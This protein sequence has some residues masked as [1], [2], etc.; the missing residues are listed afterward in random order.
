M[1]TDPVYRAFDICNAK[2]AG[3]S[4]H[5]K[6]NCCRYQ[7]YSDFGP[8]DSYFVVKRHTE[9]NYLLEQK[10]Y[11]LLKDSGVVSTHDFFKF[12]IEDTMVPHIVRQRLTKY[13]MADLVYAF[14]HFDNNKC[15]VLK[16]ILI[17]RGC[18]QS[19]YFDNPNWYDPVENPDV[20]NVYHKLGETV[21]LA[22]LSAVKMADY[23]VR[24][25][26]VGVLT[27]DNQDLNGMWYDFGDFIQ[28]VP[29]MGVPVMDTYYSLAMPV[30]SM[31]H[32]LAAEGH[33]DSDIS[34]PLRVWDVFTYDYT[35][36]RNELFHKYFKYWDTPY[37]PNCVN[38]G[39]DRCVLHCAN[40]NTLF[41]MVIPPTS[42]GPLVQKIYVDGVPFVVS[43]G[44]HYKELGVVFN[45]D[46]KLHS[47]RLS[48]SELLVYAAD[49]AM[50]VAASTALADHRTVCLSVAALTTGVTFQTVKPGHFNQDFY[51]FAIKCGFF[52]EGSSIELKHF[53][54]AQDGNAA[55]KDYNYYRYN[56]PTMCDIK[57]LLFTMEVVDKYFECY[58]GGCL[59]A[60][61]VI[62]ANY[63]K[64][65][66]FPFNKFGK[67]R[68]YY[69]SLSYEDQDGLFAY[70]KRNVLPTITQMNLKY[71]ISAKERAR[72]VAGVSIVSTMTNRQYHQK[73]LK[74]IAA[75]RGATVVI[76]TTKFY[77]GW[78]RMLRTLV[79]DVDNPHLMG[80]D[81]PKCDRAMPNML[82]IFASLI[83]ARKHQTCCN[84]SERFYRLANECAQVL[85]EMVLCGGGFYVKP[86]G[87]SSGDSTT[88][89]ANSVFNICQAVTANLGTLLS[90]DGNK[91]YNVAVKELQRR[92]YMG[93]YRSSTL[94]TALV[95]DYYAFLRK[96]FSMMILSDDGVV[97]YNSEYAA[98][99]Y[100]ADIQGFKETLYYQ[101]NVFMSESKCWVESDIEKGPHEFCSQHTM[102]CD[103][104]GE[105]V[106][107]PYPDPS[108]IL[109]AGCFVDDLIK[110][111][112]TLLLERY[113]SLAIDAY[114][115][116]KHSDPEYQKV[117]WLY[118]QYIK[119]L[120]EELT[121]HM[122]DTYSV[123]ISSENACKYW[124]PEFYENM[125]SEST[126]L[127][128]VGVCVVCNS[129]T[130]LRCGSCLR[131][132]FL[133][134]KCCYDHVM[135]TNH[136]LV[137]S[138]TPYVCNSP[139]CDQAD[140]TQLY[141]GG[142]SY[143]CKLHKPPIA[144][145]LCSNGQVF[146]LYKNMCTGSTDVAD[147]N[148]LST[149]DW[150]S[151]EDYV[152]ANTVS[153]RLRLFAAETLRATEEY[154]KQAYASAVIK[155]VVSERELVLQWEPGKVRPPLNRNYVFTGYHIAKNSKI[156]LGEYVFEKA[157]F[158]DG[159]TYRSTTTYK[160]QVGDKFV[161]TSHS[162][163]TLVSPTLV[164]QERYSKLVGLYP[165]LHMPESYAGNICHYQRIG[166]SKYTT[167]QGPPGTG[168][169]HLAIGLAIYYP[170]AKIVYTACSHAAV[171][172]LCEKA[173]LS[174]PIN[175]CSRIVPA[176]AR[177]ECFSRFKV[178]D[179]GAQYVFSTINALPETSVD[180]LVV[181]E[182]SMCTNYDLSMINARV[183]A[184]HIVYIGD[185]SQLPAPRTLLTRG[186]L[187]PEH[188][189]AICR[190]MVSVG[191]DIFLGIC[192]RCPKE[193][194]ST[195]S[196]LVY[197]N[198]LRANKDDT[199]QCFKCYFK[200]NV[201][202][203]ASSA[204]NKPQLML[205]REFITQHPLWSK[206]VF[207]SPYNSQNAV[208]RKMLGLQTQT[209]DSSQGSEFDYVIFTQTSDTSHALNLNRFN[210]AITRARKG[211]LCVMSDMTLFESLQFEALD[212]QRYGK[213]AS[214]QSVTVGLFKDCSKGDALSP[215][216]A[217]TYVSVNDKY[218][219][220]D[221]LCV[222]LEVDSG[223]IPYARLISKMGFKFDVNLPDYGK[224]FITKE[225]AI[226]EVRGWIGFDV[227]G[228]HACGPNLGT[229]L[230]LQVGFSTG[231][232][233]LVTPTGFVD[234][235]D[236]TQVTTVSARAPP[237]EQFKHLVPLLRKGEPWCVVRKRIVNMLCDTLDGVSDSV[238][239][240][241]WAH[242]FELTTMHYFCKVGK[243][244]KCYMCSR[245]AVLYASCYD[246]YSCWSHHSHVGGADYI[247]NPFLV[248]VQQWGYSGNLQAN[249]DVHCSVH[250]GAH[251]ASCDAIMTRCLAVYTCFAKV[252]WNLTY[253]II[254]NELSINKSCRRLQRTMLNAVVRACGVNKIY[255]IGNPK[256][257]PVTGVDVDWHFYDMN[258]VSDRVQSLVYSYEVHKDMFKDGLT[259]FWNC[260]VD[261]YPANA[262]VCRFD[263]RV[264]SKLNLPGYDGGSLYVNQHAFHTSAFDKRAFTELKPLPFFYYSASDCETSQGHSSLFVEEL[265]YVPLK[266]TVCITRCNLG[267]A[268][269][270]KHASEYRDYLAAYNE[271]VAAG[272]TFWVT[273]QFDIYNLWSTFTKL[274]ALEN[275]SYNVIKVGHY[276]QQPGE[277]PTAVQ[278]D[279]V[280]VRVDGEDRLVF[281]NKTT[282]P[283]NVAYELWAKRNVN[284]VPE[285]KLFRNL[286]ID[287]MYGCVIW[288][289]VNEC[290]LVNNTVGVMGYTDVARSVSDPK[291]KPLCVLVDGRV[292]NA[293]N[294]FCTLVNAVYFSVSKPKC[295]CIKGPAH[296]MLQG[297]VIEA[298][299][300]GSQFWFAMRV[301]GEFVNLTSSYFTMSRNVDDFEA[302]S[303]M[304][305]DFL[306]LSQEDFMHKYDLEGYG[307]EHIVYGEFRGVIGGLHLLIG[308]VR[309]KTTFKIVMESVL[310]GDTITSYA[311]VDVSTAAHKQVCTMF[312]LLLDDFVLLVKSLDRS[313]VSKVLNI[314]LDFKLFRFM[315]WC[316]DGGIATFYPQLQAREDW[317]PGYTMPALFKVQHAVL[318]PCILPNYGQPPRLPSG[319]MMNVAKY[320]QL[321]QYL[322]TCTIAVP[323]RMRVV[324]FGAGS[325]KGVSPGS[326]VLRQWLP[327]DAVLVDNDL[328]YSASDA[329]YT[330]LGDCSVISVGQKWDLIIS[331]MYDA[332]TKVEFGENIS[333]DGFFTFLVGFIKARLAIGGS[334]AIKI[335]ERSWSADLY[336]LMGQFAWWT[337]FC[338][339][340]NASSSEGFLI[341]VNYTGRGA[342]LDGYQ[343]HANYVFWRNSVVMHVSSYSL[344]N[345]NK[346]ELKLKGSAVML[347]KEEQVNELVLNLIGRGKLLIRDPGVIQLSS[348]V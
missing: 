157:D 60:S 228:A 240:V 62:V 219:V 244:R 331:D 37:H 154:A 29:G 321:C 50:H 7:E 328:V 99:G 165:T 186:T 281:E 257:I 312:D 295:P 166:L 206:A 6:Y 96:H 108:R 250:K 310:T 12:K 152:L 8:L 19:T 128:S 105:K 282:L 82:R 258:P 327:Y 221:E 150:T 9:E 289:Y 156:Q 163:N 75:A 333:K 307:F 325:D 256:A 110:T 25:G 176:K 33:V 292:D 140:V 149:C 80:W 211:I 155:E 172:A 175:R 57:Q 68:L 131:R 34:K 97:C 66:G 220:N 334:V 22:L 204:I 164:P 184:K 160:L 239:F 168:K 1:E 296:S 98:R 104:G 117:F 89:Y 27:L 101:N 138:V 272:F 162:V 340:V 135:G 344:H 269:C 73:M 124:E 65:S 84:S 42:F 222:H 119:K 182:V 59:Q 180:L 81:Y 309:R 93:I 70:T 217:P 320:T 251:V 185:P 47:H 21:R 102:L 195:V 231:V 332:A 259:M 267:G 294:S 177:V 173:F 133:C 232:N 193:I 308:A 45:Q 171:D 85:C 233:F 241:T 126:T 86:G 90:V 249:H 129:Q 78:N 199:K 298:P 276:A 111:D 299:D 145:P 113:V 191:P 279:K 116:S 288:D 225:Q 337:C 167:V 322:N 236:G 20:I 40:F 192:Y 297:V 146:G 14:R 48:L 142:M 58:E 266:S 254:A 212:V 183:K 123:M 169:S 63:D 190:L 179:V 339:S 136:K 5:F 88:A 280:F 234:T 278:G 112:G 194:V 94:D 61:Q 174:L 224:F 262:F 54:F 49:P 348:D 64:S 223:C 341:G 139:G 315:L 303:D 277:L 30:Y 147:F 100:V 137:L 330:L 260:N 293:Y 38:C 55:I 248:D 187:A 268:V 210:V 69:D 336:A 106:Y 198:K 202:H 115:L 318:E 107:L 285:C 11:E 74:S 77:G 338:T 238:T 71:A 92:L 141:L 83:L 197:D 109:G 56:L 67:A 291:L 18:C 79:R 189:N 230:P 103:V 15:D 178:N 26:L 161:L 201:T 253:P 216:Y 346:F 247:Y 261:H 252:D 235:P 196:A 207:I 271:V 122:L 270:R 209:V 243:E 170:A 227:E 306:N 290:P 158:G 17:L 43:I 52:K 323:A 46:V 255:D 324:H 284:V 51:D 335:T 265:D 121:G 317:R 208:A 313:V 2:L 274:Q 118:L 134:C 345:L 314:S 39:D 205:V 16:E 53:F 127:Q 3:F 36:F 305:R 13:T 246:A 125:Y 229:N 286:G 302:A 35:S 347:L 245:R 114:P 31:T 159:V 263:T 10:C 342:L 44:Y 283:T 343:M 32:M 214:M 237:G 215:A 301:N 273:P 218:K 304:E 72:T 95:S 41:S 4:L 23:M 326:S 311:V 329:D 200:G 151:S 181:D 28:T 275:V 144:F 120:H 130:S 319:V 143:Y 300:K 153:E 287:V 132:P 188:F 213:R 148:K 76:G 264:L 226:K 316:K 24:A 203:D 242:G 87:T 91:I